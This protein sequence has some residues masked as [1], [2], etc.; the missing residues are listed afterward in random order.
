MG[1]EIRKVPPNWQHPKVRCPHRPTCEM[2]EMLGNRDALIS[3]IKER[4]ADSVL[5][6]H[7]EK[8]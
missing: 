4:I 3:E 5:G 8:K 2:G 1:R 6:D 7:R